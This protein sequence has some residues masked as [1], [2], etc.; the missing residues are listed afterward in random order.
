MVRITTT[1]ARAQ[2]ADAIN[3]VSYGGERIVLDRNGKDV[4]ALVSIE[5]LELLQLLEDRIDVAAAKEAL[6]DGETINWEGLKK[7][8]EL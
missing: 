3:R 7:E 2:F 5:D 8:L 6:A 4:A 1:Q